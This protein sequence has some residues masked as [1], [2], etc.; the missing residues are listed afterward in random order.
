VSFRRV[1]RALKR[2]DDCAANCFAAMARAIV[3]HSDADMRAAVEWARTAWSIALRFTTAE[4]EEALREREK[5][6][7]Q[8]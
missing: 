5:T 2:I 3:Y 6:D 7:V 1:R 8:R 4:R